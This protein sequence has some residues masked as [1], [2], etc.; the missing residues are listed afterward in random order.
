MTTCPYQQF[1]AGKWCD[2]ANGG[3]WKVIN[4]ATEEPVRE[5]PFGDAEDVRRAI[6]AAA[7]A[8][9]AWSAMTAWERGA[10]LLKTADLIRARVD[11]LAPTNIAESG[12]PLADAK[13]DWLAAAALFEWFAEEGKRAYGRTLPCRKP[14]KR[15]MV[16]KQPI[17]V[18]GTITAWNFPAYNPAR[19]WAAA[20]AAGC[21]VVGRPSEYTPLTAM[22][23]TALLIEAGLPSGVLNLVSGDPAAM[24]Q[25]MLNN[26]A[27]RKISFTGSTRVG[28]LLMDGA[29]RT[30]KRLSLECGGNAPVIVFPDADMD[31]VMSNAAMAKCRNVGQVCIAPQRF[32]VHRDAEKKF[33]EGVVPQMQNL[34]VG[35]GSSADSQVG[36]LINATQRDRVEALVAKSADQGAQVLCGGK[37]PAAQS[38]GYF[39]EPT[40]LGGVTQDVAA[41]S[42]EIFGPVLPVTPFESVDEVIAMANATPYGLAAYVFTRDL[43]T[44]IRTYEGL[45][46]GMVAVND[47]TAGSIEGPFPGWK[48]SG[49]GRECGQEGLEDYMETKLVGIG[50]L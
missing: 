44:A 25:E 50:G 15:L 38:R 7:A 13:G 41:F 19:S 16:L 31:L 40:V 45:E 46:F 3:T 48:Q 12:K 34:K 37:R 8:L 23:M 22:E 14:G 17:G 5:V 11:A 26:T 21:T 32:L 30:M 39:Y 28:R 10:I 47:W 20:L 4:P 18:V 9:P 35:P 29:S 27:L 36:P 43:K 33:I 49:I 24:G 42:E 2:A 1:I 6:A